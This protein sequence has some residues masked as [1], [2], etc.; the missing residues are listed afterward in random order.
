MVEIATQLAKLM[1]LTPS[2]YLRGVTLGSA[3]ADGVSVHALLKGT[4]AV[5]APGIGGNTGVSFWLQKPNGS[6]FTGRLVGDRGVL[7]AKIEPLLV[8]PL[9]RHAVSFRIYIAISS[10]APRKTSEHPTLNGNFF[11]HS[12]HFRPNILANPLTSPARWPLFNG[13]Q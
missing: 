10:L 7:A 1:L 4:R 9:A 12:T 13:T 8:V 3:R 5:K 11:I 6:G 2:T